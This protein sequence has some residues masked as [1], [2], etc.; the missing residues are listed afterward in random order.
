MHIAM[1][2]CMYNTYKSTSGSSLF[3]EKT[4]PKIKLV[5]IGAEGAGKKFT[6]S[7][8]VYSFIVTVVATDCGFQH[9][10]YLTSLSTVVLN[11]QV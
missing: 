5:I 9:F 2:V 7:S 4:Y 8:T 11:L 10:G 3:N 1:Y 6:I